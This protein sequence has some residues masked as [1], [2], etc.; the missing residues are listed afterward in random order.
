MANNRIQ[1]SSTTYSILYNL[2]NDKKIGIFFT[3]TIRLNNFFTNDKAIKVVGGYD[4]DT[5]TINVFIS[6]SFG[7]DIIN[8]VV[9]SYLN[10]A[11]NEALAIILSESLYVYNYRNNG[12]LCNLD[13][14]TDWYTYYFEETISAMT[15]RPSIA[16]QFAPMIARNYASIIYNKI[17]K[18]IIEDRS[19]AVQ[20]SNKG[21][22]PELD[23]EGIPSIKKGDKVLAKI[24]EDTV[25]DVF[26]ANMTSLSRYGNMADDI[27]KY[28]DS[29]GEFGVFIYRNR[30]LNLSIDNISDQPDGT[31]VP[32]NKFINRAQG[33]EY[34]RLSRVDS[35]N[36]EADIAQTIQNNSTLSIARDK[37]ESASIEKQVAPEMALTP[38]ST[39][40]G[41]YL[42]PNNNITLKDLTYAINATEETYKQYK[43]LSD[44]IDKVKDP[45]KRIDA[46]KAL[47]IQAQAS[48]AMY[49]D[50][51][52]LFQIVSQNTPSES[53]FYNIGAVQK[54]TD[55]KSFQNVN[56]TLMIMK[57]LVDRQKAMQYKGLSKVDKAHNVEVTKNASEITSLSNRLKELSKL[58]GM[59]LG[60]KEAATINNDITVTYKALATALD[61]KAEMRLSK[62]EIQNREALIQNDQDMLK[63]IRYVPN[64]QFNNDLRKNL[65]NTNN[66][67]LSS[68]ASVKDLVNS[69]RLATDY[70]KKIAL[71]LPDGHISKGRLLGNI[72]SFNNIKDADSLRQYVDE[73][74]TQR[75]QGVLNPTQAMIDDYKKRIIKNI[76]S[77]VYGIYRSA[78]DL[79]ADNIRTALVNNPIARAVVANLHNAGAI[80]NLN[81]ANRM[82]RLTRTDILKIRQQ[83]YTRMSQNIALLSKHKSKNSNVVKYDAQLLPNQTMPNIQQIRAIVKAADRTVDSYINKNI[84]SPVLHVVDERN[85]VYSAMEMRERSLVSTGLQAIGAII[86]SAP[87]LID[88]IKFIW[89]SRKDAKRLYNN[90]KNAYSF[91]KYMLPLKSNMQGIFDG[92][93]LGFGDFADKQIFDYCYKMVSGVKKMYE[94]KKGSIKKNYTCSEIYM[95]TTILT[96]ILYANITSGNT[97]DSNTLQLL[98]YANKGLETFM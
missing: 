68:N 50:L 92:T 4:F 8:D 21:D 41:R 49:T 54:S 73:K 17:E 24:F 66:V 86:K 36:R 82:R 60:S 58:S 44:G 80:R 93:K 47:K 83:I 31:K 90:L 95:P 38:G 37:L 51:F 62:Q 55:T 94:E 9:N 43:A 12:K 19:P 6:W 7:P 45:D 16:E 1:Y 15:N 81:A 42:L 57:D 91:F 87:G 78:N 33:K 32:S 5:K 67:I 18:A 84:V 35:K 34:D 39:Y 72:R 64:E 20:I 97:L 48:N 69:I 3:P 30:D 59:S 53:Y 23:I 74:V 28:V 71:S 76:S 96:K 70:T 61:G 22:N 29:F 56:S 63:K 11:C 2:I 85:R 26:K 27:K 79:N 52:K 88:S 65:T 10:E 46:L 14:V 89:D 75:M 77:N 25:D 13:I 98:T 40:I